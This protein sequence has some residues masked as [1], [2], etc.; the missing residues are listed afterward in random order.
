MDGDGHHPLK[1]APQIH[2]RR[3]GDQGDQGRDLS[4]GQGARAHQGLHPRQS[5]LVQGHGDQQ[6]VEHHAP[7][8]QGGLDAAVARSV[9]EGVLRPT[10]PAPGQA[11][12]GPAAALLKDPGHGPAEQGIQ[13][14][15]SRD[16]VPYGA[17][18]DRPVDA[19]LQGQ[20]KQG[21]DHAAQQKEPPAAA[22]SSPKHQPQPQGKHHRKQAHQG[23]DSHCGI[24]HIPAFRHFA[25]LLSER[26]ILRPEGGRSRK[27]FESSTFPQG[28]GYDF[29][30]K[31]PQRLPQAL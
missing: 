26:S 23:H 10:A 31:H 20:G 21:K 8:Q 28:K 12:G 22:A 6:V 3:G 15:V 13:P 24:G 14:Q 1:A 30:K 16:G 7:R 25:S 9:H 5:V 17:V 2:P 4:V 18:Q 19:P 27:S 11:E 29:V